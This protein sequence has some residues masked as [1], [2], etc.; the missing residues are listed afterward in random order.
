MRSSAKQVLVAQAEAADQVSSP[1]NTS[2]VFAEPF[3][4]IERLYLGGPAENPSGMTPPKAAWPRGTSGP[5]GHLRRVVVT[6][7]DAKTASWR[8]WLNRR[9]GAAN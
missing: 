9:D 2:G 5:T 8:A 4:S 6:L 3:H 7:D 1:A